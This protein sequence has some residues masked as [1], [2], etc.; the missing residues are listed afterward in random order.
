MNTRSGPFTMMS[1]M[2]SSSSSGCSGPSP[3]MSLTSSAASW[4]CSRAFSWIR[5]SV[6]MSPTSFSI[7]GASLSC[8]SAAAAAGSSWDSASVRNSANWSEV[9]WLCIGAAITG[10]GGGGGGGGSP[11]SFSVRRRPNIGVAFI[12]T[13]PTACR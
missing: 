1:A 4:R 7:S 2:L 5:R 11:L 9:D 13:C 10:L 3:S 12:P 8:G 6:A